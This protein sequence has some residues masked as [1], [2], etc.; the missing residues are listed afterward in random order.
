MSPDMVGAEEPSMGAMCDVSGSLLQNSWT[1]LTVPPSLSSDLVSSQNN[2]FWAVQDC[3]LM[4]AKPV[5]VGTTE[6]S[7]QMDP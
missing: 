7:L 6:K 4:E 2:P 5:K 1:A 3:S